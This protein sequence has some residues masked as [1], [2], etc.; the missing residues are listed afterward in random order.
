MFDPVTTSDH[1]REL[2]ALRTDA[3]RRSARTSPPGRLRRT[4]GTAFVRIGLRLTA[5]GPS[6]PPRVRSTVHDEAPACAG[7]STS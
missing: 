7:A 3:L 5:G 6:P 4:T 2:A 1:R